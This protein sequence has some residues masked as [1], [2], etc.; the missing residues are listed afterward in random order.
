MRHQ[1]SLL[2]GVAAML[3]ACSLRGD[4]TANGGLAFTSWTVISIGG[5]DTV[6]EA[7]PTMT[8]AA[9]G[10]VSGSGGCNQYS[11]SFRTDGDRIAFGPMSSTLMGCEG[12]RGQQ[13]AVFLKA[14]DDAAS[15]RQTENGEL[16]IGGNLGMV[17]RPGIAMGPPG[18]DLPSE[19]PAAALAG[20]SWTLTD[21]G[22]MTDFAGLV[23]TLQF[24]ADGTVAGFT[25]CN[26]FHAPYTATGGDLKIG[27]LVTTKMACPRASE[28]EGKYLEW[29]AVVSSWSLGADGRLTL[30]GPEPLTFVRG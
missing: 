29:L 4:D 16:E 1:V 21:L 22:S 13:E 20:T 30:G 25:G 17:A 3:V 24:G 14:L 15:W 6:P 10:T 2:I 7:R 26:R 9:D 19:A 5:Q 8:F 28:V 23:P 18:Q 11:G 27:S 12:Q